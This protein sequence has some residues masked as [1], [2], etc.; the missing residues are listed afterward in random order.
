MLSYKRKLSLFDRITQ[1]KSGSF[2]GFE[3]NFHFFAN[4][5]FWVSGDS[6]GLNHPGNSWGPEEA[7]VLHST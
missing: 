2:L 5:Q 4:T 6:L 1:D 7:K 3:C